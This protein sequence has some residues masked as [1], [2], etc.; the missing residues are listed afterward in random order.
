MN[1]NAMFI[2]GFVSHRARR[3]LKVKFIPSYV[4]G[5]YEQCS[6]CRTRSTCTEGL[7]AGVGKGGEESALRAR[8]TRPTLRRAL[9][10]AD[11]LRMFFTD[12]RCG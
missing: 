8:T 5:T 12:S 4:V 7:P 3:I 6:T 2:V 1:K 9:C 10:R 11:R